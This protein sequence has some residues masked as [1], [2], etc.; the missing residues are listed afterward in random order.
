MQGGRKNGNGRK[1]RPGR[2]RWNRLVLLIAGA[3]LTITGAVK[4]IGYGSDYI[5][6]RRTA[7]ELRQIYHQ[8]SQDSMPEAPAAPME[9]PVP[10]MPSPTAQPASPVIAA[11]PA[12][13]LAPMPYPDNPQ[14]KTNSQFKALQT[15]NRD[16]VGWLKIEKLLD[17]P[18]VQRDDVF[19]MD[20]DALGEKNVNGA[21]FLDSAVSLKSRPYSLILYGHN[22]KT[23]A[24]FGSLRN[25]E[26]A[27]FYHNN[28]FISFD[29]MYEKGCYVIFSVTSISTEKADS[30]YMDFFSLL[31]SNVQKRQEMINHLMSMSV[32]TC[33]VDVQPED[34]LL[35]LV[36]CLDKDTDRRLVAARRIRDWENE[37]ELKLLVE[38][39]RKR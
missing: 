4:L 14:L 28:P 13:M 27:S 38:E 5:S 8:D 30:Q 35:F 17:E 1:G 18:V 20:H 29:S 15:E 39:S 12:P 26:N 24:M 9:S 2:F 22:M 31:S 11:S 6:S 33:T 3:A 21:I 37:K 10:V 36:T 25:Y 23:G 16:I 19:Y 34:Q 32:H 7:D